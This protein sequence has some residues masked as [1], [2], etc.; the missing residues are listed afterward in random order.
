MAVAG[1]VGDF[2]FKHP[3]F[4]GLSAAFRPPSLGE[5]F[6]WRSA[7]AGCRGL[8]GWDGASAYYGS[9]ACFF[10]RGV[11]WR[12]G[13]GHCL[14]V[15]GEYRGNGFGRPDLL[16]SGAGFNRVWADAD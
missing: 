8:L 10:I 13:Y 15:P 7:V 6:F 2:L 3:A 5:E 16:P 4:P 12:V 9:V 11:S 1:G 14:P